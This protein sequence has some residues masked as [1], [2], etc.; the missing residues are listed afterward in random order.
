MGLDSTISRGPFQSLQ[1]HD[2]ILW[3]YSKK[4]TCS[5]ITSP[6][7]HK[8]APTFADYSKSKQKI[9][10]EPFWLQ[11]ELWNSSSSPALAPWSLEKSAHEP[12]RADANLCRYFSFTHFHWWNCMSWHLYHHTRSFTRK[13]KREN[14]ANWDREAPCG[15][16]PHGAN[17]SLMFI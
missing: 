17:S 4:H 8:D 15:R 9:S 2:S 10:Q 5:L 6:T 13:S 12:G 16:L 3:L 11:T 1:F 7:K 14:I